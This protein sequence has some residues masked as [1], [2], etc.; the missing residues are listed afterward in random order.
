MVEDDGRAHPLAGSFPN[1]FAEGSRSFRPGAVL[2]CV[3]I[4]HHP[5]VV[6]VLA[7]DDADGTEALAEVDLVVAGDDGDRAAADRGGDLDPHRA[8]A[9]GTAPD[10]HDVIR[11]D[12]V[13]RPS[14]QHAVSGRGTEHV[15]ARLLPSKVFGLG[16]TLV[17]LRL[18]ELAEAT[19]VGLVAPDLGA[20]GQHRVASGQHPWILRVPPA[21]MDD[22]LV[23]WLHVGDIVADL[24]DDP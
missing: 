3:G 16:L 9:P 7:I 10:Q 5:P 14:H 18:G 20:L 17:R 4:G 6:E 2:W 13:R 8:K 12:N 1:R 24:P 22:Y 19:V 23:A 21:T 11:L 15:A